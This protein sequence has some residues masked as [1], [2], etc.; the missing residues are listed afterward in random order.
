MIPSNIRKLRKF[1]I[2]IGYNEHEITPFLTDI[3]YYITQKEC[4]TKMEMNAEM[5]S[6]GW[7]IGVIDEFIFERINSLIEK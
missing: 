1:L 4:R 5:E 2:K 7:G 6:L 3:F